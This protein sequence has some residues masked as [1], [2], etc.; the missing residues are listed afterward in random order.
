MV[1]KA[2]YIILS[3]PLIHEVYGDK[4]T[5]VFRDP[6]LEWIKMEEISGYWHEFL[7]REYFTYDELLDRLLIATVDLKKCPCAYYLE[8]HKFIATLEHP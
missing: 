8:I 5:K 1:Y 4:H 6:N 2:C 7:D 3:N